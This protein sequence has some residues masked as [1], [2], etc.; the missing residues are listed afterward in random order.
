VNAAKITPLRPPTALSVLVVEDDVLTRCA[1]ADELR[2]DGYRVLEASSVA[3]AVAIL[4]TVPVHLIFVDLHV[5][6]PRDGL[7]VAR[8]AQDLNLPP[9]IILTSGKVRPEDV[10]EAAEFGPFVVKPYLITRVLDLIR[11]TLDPAGN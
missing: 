1:I 2:S 9:R 4:G 10:P 11:S 6:G 7:R 3:D 5:P 8:F